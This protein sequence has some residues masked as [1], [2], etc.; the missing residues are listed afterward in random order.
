MHFDGA[1]DVLRQGGAGKGGGGHG[2][3]AAPS[4]HDSRRERGPDLG[5]VLERHQVRTPPV[6]AQHRRAHRAALR[7]RLHRRGELDAAETRFRLALEYAPDFP[8]VLNN[9]GLVRRD[10]GRFEE[11]I[12]DG[13]IFYVDYLPGPLWRVPANGGTAQ[14]VGGDAQREA[15]FY[16]NAFNMG[17][18]IFESQE[19]ADRIRTGDA[20]EVDPATGV[21]KNLTRGEEFRAEPFPAFMI[22]LIEAGGLIPYL[23]K[24]G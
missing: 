18:P 5:Q 6:G 24:E 1:F 12:V 21:I 4:G 13:T 10:L 23:L 11:A 15:I 2:G 8:E 19:A 22:D 17:L 7:V 16:R 3:V 9:L 20:V 14:P